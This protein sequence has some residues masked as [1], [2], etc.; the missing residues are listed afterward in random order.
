MATYIPGIT[1]YIP[2]TQPFKPD[3]NFLGNVLQ[4]KQSKYDQNY[5]TLSERYGLLL[6]SPLARTDNIQKRDEFFRVIDQDIKKVSGLDLS[7][8]QNVDSANKVFDSFLQNKDIVYD[9]AYT[10]K[11]QDQKE[12]GLGY[13]GTEGYWDEGMKYLDYKMQEFQNANKE[14]SMKMSP[15]EYVP[16]V[17]LQDQ[18]KTYVMDMFGKSSAFGIEQIKYSEDGKYKITL[19]NGEMLSVPLQTLL[20]NAFGDDP[21]VKAMYQAKAYVDR[22]SFVEQNLSKFNGDANAAEDA[23]FNRIDYSVKESK[24]YNQQTQKL[25]EAIKAKKDIIEKAIKKYGSS[26]DDALAKAYSAAGIDVSSIDK[27]LDHSNEINKIADSIFQAG[28]DRGLKRQAV[29]AFYSNTLLDNEIIQSANNIA[30]VTGSIDIKED[31]YHLKY[32]EHT[33]KVN[34]SLMDSSLR[35]KEAQFKFGLDDQLNFNKKLYD[36][37]FDQISGGKGAAGASSVRGLATSPSNSPTLVKDFAGTS[38]GEE[39]SKEIEDNQKDMAKAAK[40]F[41]QSQNDYTSNYTNTLIDIT[42]GTADND[43]SQIRVAKNSLANIWGV[44]RKN[45]QGKI[46]GAGYDAESNSFF[47]ERGNKISDPTKLITAT[48]SLRLYTNATTVADENKNLPSHKSFIDFNGKQLKDQRSLSL[49]IYDVAH[50]TFAKN[51]EVIKNLNQSEEL[52]DKIGWDT[53]FTADNQLKTK[54]QFTKDYIAAMQEYSPN[55]NVDADDAADKYEDNA[56]IYNKI[57]Y[58]SPKGIESWYGTP[59]F[60]MLGG[61]KAAGNAFLYDANTKEP[62]SDGSRGLLGIY[63]DAINNGIFTYDNQTSVEDAEDEA[64]PNAKLAMEN[65]INDL[66]SGKIS[67]KEAEAFNAQL[68]YMDTALSNSNY[69]GALVKFPQKWIDEHKGKKGESDTWADDEGLNKGVGVYFKK[70][71]AKNPLTQ[72]FKLKPYDILINHEPVI[73]NDEKGGNITINKRSSDGTIEVHGNLIGYS[74]K[75]KEME[76]R[77]LYYKYTNDPGGENLVVGLKKLLESV[78]QTNQVYEANNFKKIF[79]PSELPDI[80]KMLEEA[81]GG[82]NTQ[83]SFSDLFF[84]QVQANK[85]EFQNIR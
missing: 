49:S 54:A 75:G 68:Y 51:N 42:K 57:Y 67:G 20:K 43:A 72:T 84:Q 77:P 50:K 17:D 45:E 28:S 19:K 53:Y 70:D 66:K 5:K 58:N 21:N 7:L 47:D 4:V 83:P 55:S 62:A 36:L 63:N 11:H 78:S 37:S 8:Q 26:G 46:I 3:F 39:G 38:T 61:G 69:A 27:T 9:M 56:E 24:Y 48:N 31:P 6:N 14:D 1:D 41:L 25:A 18:A 29:D 59:E 82:G 79:N 40:S 65:W 10:K 52:E 32:Y 76:S 30:R 64:N 74:G 2:Q 23:Y 33:L 71:G 13:K 73:L 16:R 80:K 60:Q 35:M 85:K 15:G 81:G 22:K 34:E 12:I 44:A